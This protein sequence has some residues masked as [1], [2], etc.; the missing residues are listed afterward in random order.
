MVARPGCCIVKGC[1]VEAV[2]VHFGI[3]ELSGR[4]GRKRRGGDGGDCV[5]VYGM[6]G[7]MGAVVVVSPLPKDFNHK[8]V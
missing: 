6:L 1:E 7:C 3:P 8:L 5:C 2:V 4:D